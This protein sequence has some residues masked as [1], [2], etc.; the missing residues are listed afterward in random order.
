[1]CIRGREAREMIKTFKDKEAK[2]LFETG[3]SGKLPP[4]IVRRAEAV[5]G[6]LNYA[7]DYR[8]FAGFTAFN[9]KVMKG[10]KKGLFSLRISKRYRV[11]TA[12][13]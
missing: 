12:P 6:V 11:Y 8:Y 9:F 3:K 7:T 1:M 2:K 13:H 10:K 5:L 4:E